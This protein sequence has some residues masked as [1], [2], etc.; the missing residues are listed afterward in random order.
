MFSYN[1]SIVIF[2]SVSTGRGCD[3]SFIYSLYEESEM[4]HV[5]YISDGEYWKHMEEGKRYCSKRCRGGKRCAKMQ[6]RKTVCKDA[7][8]ENGVLRNAGVDREKLNQKE[9]NNL[10][11]CSE[12]SEQAE[13]RL[14]SALSRVIFP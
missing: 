10:K 11:I 12:C 8:A 3:K 7:G 13:Q 6:G 9:R 4:K 5:P 14:R 2:A 1:S